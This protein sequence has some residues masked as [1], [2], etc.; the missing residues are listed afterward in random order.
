MAGML[1]LARVED[2][3]EV[4]RRWSTTPSVARSTPTPRW[5]SADRSDSAAGSACSSTPENRLPRSLGHRSRSL[6]GRVLTS[7]T[8]TGV[9]ARAHCPVISVPE[10]WVEGSEVGR[11]VVG[12][13][14]SDAAHDALDLGFREARRR[15]ASL[16]ALHAWKLPMVY[17]GIGYAS[18]MVEDWMAPAAEEMDKNLARFR[19]AY[20]DVQ[21][22]VD[23]QHEVA[24][25]AL[26]KATEHADPIVVGRR[27]H[28]AT[29]GIY[30]G[31]LAR[32]LDGSSARASARRDIPSAPAR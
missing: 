32:W 28:G 17:D 6:P 23:L 21:I 31:S 22:E 30:L 16:V 11:V 3:T 29:W 24:G 10:S 27:G 12:V 26:L 15:R 7:S 25:P 1:P 18:T 2:F 20:P 8:T 4:G 14:E 9:A 19:E 5:R 13:D